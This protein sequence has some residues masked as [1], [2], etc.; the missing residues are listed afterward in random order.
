MIREQSPPLRVLIADDHR[1]IRA[2]IRAMLSLSTALVRCELDEAET[3]EQAMEKAD[4]LAYD[5]I[6]MDVH[7]PGRGG[8]KATE[9]ILKRH[10][11]IRVL[12]LSSYDECTYV[13]KML[14]AGAMGYV[15]KNVEPDT[16]LSAIRSVM[17]GKRF[18]SN[19]IGLKL[20]DPRLNPASPSP[21][22]R[23]TAR[24]KEIFG[25]ILA[26]F[27]DREIGA[28]LSVSKRT[29]DKH[30]QHIMRKLSV[31]NAVEL[32]EAGLRLR[33]VK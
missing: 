2:G 29:V 33:L 25:Q 14:N 30:R 3:T 24:E 21:L 6:L 5:V 26:G 19:E 1:M 32:A 11:G 10:P 20:M 18:F 16:L 9:L 8:I 13:E 15:L 27:N 23:L 17:E 31:R 12:G 7:L 4:R 22:E 28:R